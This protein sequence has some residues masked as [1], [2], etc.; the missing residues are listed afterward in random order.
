[1][2]NSSGYENFN[3][4]LWSHDYYAFQEV[5]SMSDILLDYVTLKRLH[6]Q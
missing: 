4:L 1:M 3:V 6:K 5:V 2:L